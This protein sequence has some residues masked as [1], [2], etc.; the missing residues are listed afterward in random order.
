LG[1]LYLKGS[2]V[3]QNEA[4]AVKLL[5]RAA[6]QKNA[7][8]QYLLGRIY[9]EGRGVPRDRV[10]AHMWFNLAAAQGHAGAVS[11]RQVAATEMDQNQLMEAQRLAVQEV[12]SK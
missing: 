9:W 2:G 1:R 5:Q 6:A 8:A 4:E 7:D 11:M 12:K 10:Q 3:P